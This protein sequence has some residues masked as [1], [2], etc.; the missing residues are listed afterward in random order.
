MNSCTVTYPCWPI[1]VQLLGFC[2]P[3][4]GCLF[5][6]CWVSVCQLSG[7]CWPTVGC[8]FA[9]CWVSVGQ[10]LGVCWPPTVGCLLANF[11]P[12]VSNTSGRAVASMRRTKA[13][14]SVK[15]LL[16]FKKKIVLFFTLEIICPERI[17][18]LR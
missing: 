9:N 5:A 2:L 15:I 6:N 18:S 13:I 1:V 4:V 3:T 10:L 11:C 14:A 8:L 12:S 17:G 7:V 16:P